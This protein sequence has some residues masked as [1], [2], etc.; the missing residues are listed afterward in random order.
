MRFTD[1]MLSNWPTGTLHRMMMVVEWA[2]KVTR[3]MGIRR[4]EDERIR[5]LCEN[6]KG[7]IGQIRKALGEQLR[8]RRPPRETTNDVR[9]IMVTPFASGI[10]DAMNVENVANMDEVK[11]AFPRTIVESNGYPVM[12]WKYAKPSGIMISNESAMLKTHKFR[13]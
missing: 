13:N 6:G 5:Y 11:S 8:L 12:C 7:S 9:E 4:M 1:N 10:L 3:D 2:A